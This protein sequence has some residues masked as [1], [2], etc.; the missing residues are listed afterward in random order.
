MSKK[1]SNKNVFQMA[2]DIKK[3]V[4]KNYKLPSSL[5]YEG[6]TFFYQ[7]Y[8]YI[9]SYA[10]NNLS[11]GIT[12]PSIK[13]A[14]KP[15]GDNMKEQIK[16]SDY[17]DQ[18]KRI[19]QFIKQNG[20]CPNYV[21]TV[22]S[23]KKVR[24]KVFIYS[25]AKILVFYNSKGRLP[26]E[27]LYQSS[28][29]SIKKEVTKVES[30]KEVLAYFESVFGKKIDYIDDALEIMNNRGYS[31]YYDDAYSNKESIDR[32]KAKKGINCVDSLHVVMNIAIALGKYKQIDCLHVRCSKG[33]GHVRARITTKDG[34]K[35][36]RDP[37]CCLSNNGKGAY[38]NWC[39]SNFVL[40]DVNPNWFMKNLK[41]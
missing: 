1:I 6:V 23:K 7:E 26:N 41:R 30:P 33:D 31:H 9:M 29:F 18:A 5:K 4:E 10:L 17:K 21:K 15:T 32:I 13:K 38:C 37:A 34:D 28:V 35:F 39:T 2:K 27:C 8:A 25:M 3:Y 16:P 24:P 12:V 40:L 20:K 19:V 11:K 14:S 36:Y 22:K